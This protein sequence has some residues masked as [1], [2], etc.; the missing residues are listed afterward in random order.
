MFTYKNKIFYS[1]PVQSFIQNHN[2]DFSHFAVLLTL[3]TA[4]F[5]TRR[6]RNVSACPSTETNP[7]PSMEGSKEIK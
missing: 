7:Q 2:I 1:G 4:L 6:K 5:V 3:S